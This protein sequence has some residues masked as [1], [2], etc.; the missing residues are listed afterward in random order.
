MLFQ[1]AFE[2]QLAGRS[3]G[4]VLDHPGCFA[5]GENADAALAATPR[6]IADYAAWVAS[7]NQGNCW[8]EID[9]IE[10]L[11]TDTWDVY[12]INDEFEIAQEG[13]DVDAW[14]RH[15]WKPLTV[16]DLERG[17]KLLAW[18]RADLLDAVNGLSA[19]ALNAQYPGERWN[20]L[21]ILGHVGGAEWWYLD[22]LGL[23]FAR[24]DVP[25]DPF[26]RLEKVR[27]RLLDVLPGLVGSRKVL[28]IDGEFWSP[29]KLFRRTLWH[30][31]DHTGHIHKLCSPS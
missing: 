3:I 13:Y 11:I 7:R 6:A 28:G 19:E 8:V 21:G 24:Q 26:E 16:Q 5:Y 15:D 18:S 17:E 2:N 30:E 20:I 25:K 10:L 22:R 27:A 14:F 4:W 1:V 29:R 31:R 9:E 23:G 12:T